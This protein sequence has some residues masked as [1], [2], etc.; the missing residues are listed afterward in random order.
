MRATRG[1]SPLPREACGMLHHFAYISVGLS[2]LVDGRYDMPVLGISSANTGIVH[3]RCICRQV[4]WNDHAVR[5]DE[6]IHGQ[7]SW[8]LSAELGMDDVGI[9]MP[10][11]NAHPQLE[12]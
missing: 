4:S 12:H 10:I 5:S 2:P 6:V 11:V 9:L 8:I 7:S 1:A 3:P